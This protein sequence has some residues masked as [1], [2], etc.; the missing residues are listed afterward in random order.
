MTEQIHKLTDQQIHLALADNL[1]QAIQIRM[2]AGGSLIV[3]LSTGMAVYRSGD[4][5]IAALPSVI[6]SPLTSP[7][8]VRRV[9]TLSQL[10]RDATAAT[11]NSISLSSLSTAP[12]PFLAIRALAM[13]SRLM[14]QIGLRDP[15]VPDCSGLPPEFG[16]VAQDAVGTARSAGALINECVVK[17]AEAFQR[18]CV[19]LVAQGK[20]LTQIRVHMSG[21]DVQ[22]AGLTAS[23]ECLFLMPLQDLVAA[24]VAASSEF[25]V[26]EIRRRR[27]ASDGYL[28]KGMEIL[29]RLCPALANAV[30]LASQE[31]RPVGLRLCTG[32]TRRGRPLDV[33]LYVNSPAGPLQWGCV[34]SVNRP[35]RDFILE[36]ADGGRFYFPPC[37]LSA[38]FSFLEPLPR[39]E[40]PVVRQPAGGYAW[41]HPYTGVLGRG[42]FAGARL[43][44]DEKTILYAPSDQAVALFPRLQQRIPTPVENDLCLGGQPKTIR[45]IQERLG[46]AMRDPAEADV[47]AAVTAIHDVAR[48][49]LT[50]GHENNMGG[51]RAPLSPQ[52]MLYP[53][54][55]GQTAGSLEKRTYVFTPPGT[56]RP[57]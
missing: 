35:H 10:I 15:A 56:T 36:A 9:S 31:A 52:S 39:A 26:N 2:V 34:L 40:L 23:E 46:I 53:V 38:R 32:H 37:L 57:A 45:A 3:D 18:Q 43:L 17:I 47:L 27:L 16:T 12:V 42:V 7:R 1:C 13:A 55:G 11:L 54:L 5:S 21:T 6:A 19:H 29:S 8:P 41:C 28:G 25:F 22:V 33:W 51:S 48:H 49:G 30:Y 50:R 20:A 14:E 24:T 44:H 4:T